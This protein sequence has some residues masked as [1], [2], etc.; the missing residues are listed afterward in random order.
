[1]PHYGK[2]K[3]I[4]NKLENMAKNTNSPCTQTNISIGWRKKKYHGDLGNNNFLIFVMTYTKKLYWR[5]SAFVGW[6]DGGDSKTLKWWH[7]NFNNLSSIFHPKSPLVPT[8]VKEHGK[9]IKELWF[10][11]PS[12]NIPSSHF[13]GALHT[14]Q[15]YDDLPIF[16]SSSNI[17]SFHGFFQSLDFLPHCHLHNIYHFFAPLVLS[18]QIII[19]ARDAA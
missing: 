6:M 9:Q 10:L 16:Y 3:F 4:K 7:G 8:A 13:T 2:H 17:N 18:H 12:H 11:I 1:M 15:K 5:F 14:C 19:H